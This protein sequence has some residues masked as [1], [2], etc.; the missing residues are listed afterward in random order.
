MDTETFL[1]QQDSWISICPQTGTRY[2][3]TDK[4]CHILNRHSFLR[5]VHHR[6]IEDVN[7]PGDGG[8][9]IPVVT[10]SV[11]QLFDLLPSA[12]PRCA[13]KALGQQR[14]SRTRLWLAWEAEVPP[15]AQ[16]S[17]TWKT[18]EWTFPWMDALHRKLGIS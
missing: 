7:I 11:V 10:A 8:R 9:C 17:R 2:G 14:S 15:S 16:R 12:H 4:A 3:H 18:W 13:A 6:C 1:W 5:K